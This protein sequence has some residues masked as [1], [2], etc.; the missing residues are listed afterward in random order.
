MDRFI[1]RKSILGTPRRT[2]RFVFVIIIIFVNKIKKT[3]QRQNE[4]YDLGEI[5]KKRRFPGDR[6]NTITR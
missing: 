5:K 4:F 1:F 6:M 2:T 3:R